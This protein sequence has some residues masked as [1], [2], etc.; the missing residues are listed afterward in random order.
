MGVVSQ[1]THYE[2]VTPPELALNP[3]SDPFPRSTDP[4]AFRF[5]HGSSSQADL[6]VPYP[7]AHARPFVGAGKRL[8]LKAQEAAEL[9][10]DW[11]LV[12]YAS[13]Q[14]VLTPPSDAFY[15]RVEWEHD[16]ARL[17]RPH[18]DPG[19]PV[20]VDPEVR[21]GRPAVGGISTEVLWE[22]LDAEETPEEVAEEFGLTA[23]DVVW[24]QAYEHSRRT[25]RAA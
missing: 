2:T 8:L 16:V 24:A 22:H 3:A 20:I 5:L 18:D 14:L 10:G 11:W 12:A 6:G 7:L 19:S 13:D 17:W 25:I 4:R 21:F 15:R 23:D 1:M 9:K